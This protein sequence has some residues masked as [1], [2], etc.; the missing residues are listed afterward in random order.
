M[1]SAFE[2]AAKELRGVCDPASLGFETTAGLPLLSEVLG[3]PRAVAALEF[4][5]RIGSP[6]FNLFALGQ[7]GSGRTTL[8]E[9]YLE[10]YSATQPVP[11][12][13]CYVYTFVDTRRP[14]PLSLPPGRA[15]ELTKISTHC[16][17]NCKLR[18]SEGF[19]NRGILAPSP[20]GAAAT[21]R[22]APRKT[23]ADRPPC[24]GERLQVVQGP[25]RADAGA[26][27]GRK[28]AKRRGPRTPQRPRAGEGSTGARPV[29]HEIK[30]GLRSVRE[31]EKGIRDALRAL[32]TCG[33]CHT[34]RHR[35]SPRAIPRP[36]G[37]V[38]L[39]CRVTDRH[40]GRSLW[41]ATK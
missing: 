3:Q 34:A 10:Q 14:L 31:L 25:G 17:R 15:A 6:G 23:R 19:R 37:G 39:S 13:L 7:P 41:S 32:D 8:V 38:G 20:P 36:A 24:H 4:G 21:R 30:E 26:G 9:D 18:D 5:A 2:L 22:T 1:E 28:V 35:G 40:H 12:D 27:G 16:W 11:P 29:Q 33:L